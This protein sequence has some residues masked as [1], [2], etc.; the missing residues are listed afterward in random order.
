VKQAA[1]IAPA[2]IGVMALIILLI[3]IAA[4]LVNARLA[5]NATAQ[6][7]QLRQATMT[8][9][10]VLGLQI[11]QESGIRGYV[12]TGDPVLLTP[13]SAARAQMPSALAALRNELVPLRSTLLQRRAERL[14]ALNALWEQTV[15]APS[16][17]A[18]HPKTAAHLQLRGK[19]II[20]DFRRQSELLRTALDARSDSLLDDL[21]GKLRT[22]GSISLA[23]IGLVLLSA[24]GWFVYQNRVWMEYE[25]AERHV[26]SL[27]RVVDAFHRAQ[28][29]QALPSSPYV[30]FNATYV[31]A[32][33]VT[34]MGG[35]WYDVFTLDDRR[36]VF[37]IGDVTGHGLE[38]A[39][40]MGRVR[41]T[42]FTLASIEND[43]AAIL[44][45]ANDVLRT[46]GDHIVTA[47]CG[48]IDARSGAVT[49]ATAGHPPALIVPPTGKI[50][51]LSS[52]APPLGATERL[53]VSC[54]NEQL[55]PGE[56]LVCYTDGIIENER[57]VIEGEA[58]LRR[59]L[60]SLRTSE[61][62]E[63]APAIR[64]R[65]LGKHRGRDDVA[66]L[67]IRRSQLQAVQ[68]TSAA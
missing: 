42:I 14:A 54:R 64:D 26:E 19:A 47:L 18:R 63:P 13:Y 40:V 22:I 56:M 50:R 31:P 32:E 23:L 66:I 52:S 62:R 28:L 35:D 65:I 3:P 44:E 39:I 9:D 58:R 30:S 24:V 46:Q 5:A 4:D 27:Q 15:A 8:Q 29:P 20:D 7:R 43:P 51:E 41:Q 25:S 11:D 12:A 67:T 60:S 49:L 33:E 6:Y 45:R 21:F 48:A 10:A 1:R 37:S 34:A 16:L 61:R 55:F 38:A 57:N 59:V 36:Y 53:Q 2:A 68:D 17:R